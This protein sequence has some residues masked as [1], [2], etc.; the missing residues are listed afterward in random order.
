[1]VHDAF[2]RHVAVVHDD[3]NGRNSLDRVT[4]KSWVAIDR[5]G[6]PHAEIIVVKRSRQHLQIVSHAGD[7]W[8]ALHDPLQVLLLEWLTNL[9]HKF[10]IPF[11]DLHRY[12]VPDGV[13]GV[14][15]N[16]VDRFGRDIGIGQSGGGSG[17]GAGH[18]G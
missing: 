4:R 16:L 2:E 3:V 11:I 15:P 10:Q 5:P 7:A 13:A 12:V 6:H 18:S 17:R 14:H 8:D 9:A 1:A